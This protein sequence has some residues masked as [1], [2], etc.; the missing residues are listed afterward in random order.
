MKE[1]LKIIFDQWDEWRL[2]Y[3]QSGDIENNRKTKKQRASADLYNETVNEYIEPRAST[4]KARIVKEWSD[5]LASDA[6]F[7][8]TSYTECFHAHL[9]SNYRG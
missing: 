1:Q 8:I 2:R 5:E 9:M 4:N 3:R 7:N 6:E